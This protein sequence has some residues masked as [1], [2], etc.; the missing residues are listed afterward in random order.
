MLKT[1]GWVL[2]LL[3]LGAAII[4]VIGTQRYIAPATFTEARLVV[5]PRGSGLM[6]V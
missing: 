6:A 1:L 5:I 3:V 2:A 4:A